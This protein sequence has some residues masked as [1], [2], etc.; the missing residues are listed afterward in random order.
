MNNLPVIKSAACAQYGIKAKQVPALVAGEVVG[1]IE[2]DA[3][4]PRTA[5]R[6]DSMDAFNAEIE[7]S[8]APEL[9]PWIDYD[10]IMQ[11]MA[12]RSSSF[13]PVWNGD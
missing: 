13:K 11:D 3:C 1:Y 10:P 12:H 6:F 8:A 4:N 2:T 5:M 9:T 7:K